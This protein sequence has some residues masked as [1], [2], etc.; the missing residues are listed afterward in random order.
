[1]ERSRVPVAAGRRHSVA[2]LPSGTVLA[3]GNNKA[4]ECNVE[5]WAE[6]VAVAAGNVHT[7]TNTG[8]SHTVGLC[9]DGSVLATGWNDDQQCDVAR[10]QEVVAIAA[11]WRRTLGL[12]ADGTVLA[13][14]RTAEGACDVQQWREI[15][16][17]SC[18]DWHSVG[19]RADGS[20]TAVGNNQRGQC[21]VDRWRGLSSITAGYLHTVGLSRDT[22][23]LLSRAPPSGD[24]VSLSTA[25]P[26]K[27]VVAL[28][29][30]GKAASSS[31]VPALLTGCAGKR[32]WSWVPRTDEPSRP[33]RARCPGCPG[34]RPGPARRG[35]D[36]SSPRRAEP[37][38]ASDR[39]RGGAR[40]GAG[41]RPG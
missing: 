40:R 26:G 16:V 19:I 30:H 11:G 17:V 24:A 8:R 41:S 5:R 32:E 28:P 6:V 9:L 36:C 39:D 18:G 27:P 29:D 12:L 34:D 37:R 4:G 10:W 13:T 20:A 1:M 33:A 31:H 21:A 35:A 2:V 22:F 25:D 14:G 3:V 38:V 15:V 23:R 7:A